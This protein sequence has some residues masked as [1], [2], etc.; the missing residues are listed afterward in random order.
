MQTTSEDLL[1]PPRLDLLQVGTGTLAALAS[2]AI[3]AMFLLACTFFFLSTA[4]NSAPVLFPYML[5]MTGFVAILLSL[6]IQTKF[7]SMIIPE[8]SVRSGTQALHIFGFNFMVYILMMPA[9]VFGASSSERLMMVFTV[10]ALVST[11]A[12]GIITGVVSRYRYSLLSVYSGF[13]ALILTIT[14]L[15][16]I[17]ERA[18]ISE[19]ILFLLSAALILVITLSTGL[20]LFGEY[21]YGLWYALTGQDILGGTFAEIELD[22]N[23]AIAAATHNLTQF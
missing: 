4:K 15:L 13:M 21:L 6:F 7:L 5:S 16:I 10:H 12:L 9:Y 8:Y 18:T 23:A 11:L 1:G 20:R 3:G 19:Q 14:L 2:G 17:L 22:E